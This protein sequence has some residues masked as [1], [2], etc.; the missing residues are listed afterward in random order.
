MPILRLAHKDKAVRTAQRMP[1]RLLKQVPEL[2]YGD[3][4]AEN[5]LIQ[6]DNLKALKVLIPL[7]D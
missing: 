7:Y 1:Y 4:D 6:G 3:I 5:M 2:C